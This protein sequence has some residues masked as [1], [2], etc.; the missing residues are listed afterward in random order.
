LP[1]GFFE[2]KPLR[3]GTGLCANWGL[4]PQLARP[5]LLKAEEIMGRF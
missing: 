4:S 2:E 1:A 5:L 3:T